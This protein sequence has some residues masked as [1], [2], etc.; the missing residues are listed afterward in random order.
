MVAVIKI[1][2][3]N[4]ARRHRYIGAVPPTCK[5]CSRK[6]D[7]GGGVTKDLCDQAV[8]TCNHT[9][10]FRICSKP[11]RIVVNGFIFLTSNAMHKL[12]LDQQ[13]LFSDV[14]VANV[15][16]CQSV[17]W[18]SSRSSSSGSHLLLVSAQCPPVRLSD[19]TIVDDFLS[20]LRDN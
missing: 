17:C 12:N 8:T 13:C 3:H 9:R 1:C 19:G 10:N 2:D 16:V 5:S 4:D 15:S 11:E 18:G 7:G 20:E 14:I 6:G